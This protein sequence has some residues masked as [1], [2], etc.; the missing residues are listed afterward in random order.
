MQRPVS[1]KS[2]NLSVDANGS[3]LNMNL[4]YFY[5]RSLYPKL[6]TLKAECIV[7]KSYIVCITETWLDDNVT[8]SEICI[9]GFDIVRLDRN[10]HGG[11]VIIYVSSLFIYNI[12]FTGDSSFECIIT[13]LIKS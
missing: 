12:L 5:A 6:D 11:G 3:T 10:R 8:I 9:P 1:Y 4:L 7:H 2:A 13:S